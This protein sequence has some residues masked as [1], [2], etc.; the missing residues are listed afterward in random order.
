MNQKKVLLK[1]TILFLFLLFSD[2]TFSAGINIDGNFSVSYFKDSSNQL[3]IDDVFSNPHFTYSE[4]KN[5]DF[6]ITESTTW[7]SVDLKK[8]EE[9]LVLCI[10]NAH[11]DHIE[12]YLFSGNKFIQKQISGDLVP[13]KNRYSDNPFFNF[14]IEKGTDKIFIKVKTNGVSSIPIRL[15][16]NKEYF[17]NYQSYQRFHWIYFGLVLL[18]ILSNILFLIWL[19]ESIY[20][21]YILCVLSIGIINA[22][23]FEYTFQFLWPNNPAFNKYNIAYYGSYIFIIFFTDKL[24]SVKKNLPKIYPVFLFF[25]LIIIATVVFA[26]LD[27]YNLALKISLYISPLVPIICLFS[28]ILIYIKKRTGVVKFFIIGWTAYFICMFIYVITV[29]GLL[30]FSVLSSNLIPLGSSIEI[31]FLNLAILSKINTLKQE[32]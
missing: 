21:Y 6:G 13:F 8:T 10:E 5:L 3:K 4:T 1:R 25:Y 22:V 26:L 19:K 32:K 14:L 11:L 28:G 9:N 27:K 24:L 16:S 12:I 7:I 29:M 15:Y 2:K 18:T 17:N 31:I 30:P 23:D 20:F